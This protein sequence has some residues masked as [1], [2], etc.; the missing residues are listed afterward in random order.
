[1][2]RKLRSR[3]SYANVVASVALFLA[4]TTGGAY[5]ATQITGASIK[6]G[7]VTGADVKNGS[8]SYLD[9]K[10]QTIRAINLRTGSVTGD[11]V[12]DFS[13]TN[14]DIGVLFAQ[15]NA[16]GSVDNASPGV[17]VTHLSTGDY[18]VDFGRDVTLA[19][20]VAV[21][22]N[23]ET[24][25]PPA[26]FIGVADRAGNANAVFVIVRNATGTNVDGSF[27]LIVVL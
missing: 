26:E 4:L 11:K 12:R 1:M 10:S 14:E 15:V 7:T 27:N 19:A 22:A 9:L 3:L 17:T 2:F 6:D 23:A 24:G 20:P 18:A 13:L 21:P 16:D 25:A 8:L 5:A